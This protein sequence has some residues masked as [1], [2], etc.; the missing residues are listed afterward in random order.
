MWPG[1][2]VNDVFN[3]TNRFLNDM[4]PN[5]VSPR[6]SWCIFSRKMQYF[7]CF[8]SI[9][10]SPKA[11]YGNILDAK[12]WKKCWKSPDSCVSGWVD[13]FRYQVFCLTPT[14]LGDMSIWNP[15]PAS[16]VI[17][18]LASFKEGGLSYAHKLQTQHGDVQLQ[19]LFW[20][21]CSTVILKWMWFLK[22]SENST[23]KL[24]FSYLNSEKSTL[25]SH[26]TKT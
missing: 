11:L 15:M 1:M 4:W 18:T 12:S 24:W 13:I 26:C 19:S 9:L 6:V 23:H 25:Y 5:Y 8:Q 14:Q 16:R 22:S 2:F 20:E 3:N 21:V 17:P 10:K 7:L